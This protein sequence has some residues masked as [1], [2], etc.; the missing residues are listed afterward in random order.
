M[1]RRKKPDWFKRV[2]QSPQT[3]ETI[4]ANSNESSNLDQLLEFADNSEE[5]EIQKLE[6]IDPS[7]LDCGSVEVQ[8]SNPID[9]PPPLAPLSTVNKQE[10]IAHCSEDSVIE[11]QNDLNDNPSSTIRVV[12]PRLTEQV[13]EIS[14]ATHDEDDFFGQTIALELKKISRKRK[15]MRLKADIFK[16]LLDAQSDS[17]E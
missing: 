10:K 1:K 13:P 6:F 11:I 9:M 14:V 17:D 12:R 7:Y 15:K 5:I 4:N 8:S 16:L 2:S 3:D